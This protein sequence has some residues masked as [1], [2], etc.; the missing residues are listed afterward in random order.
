VPGADV[1][2]SAITLPKVK[3][4]ADLDAD[5]AD[6]NNEGVDEAKERLVG[7]ATAVWNC[8]TWPGGGDFGET[9]G[10]ARQ[11]GGGVFMSWGAREGVISIGWRER[12]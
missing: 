10:H 6:T 5:E 1:L 11:E 12:S 2:G 9:G 3:P 7:V 8:F 4:D